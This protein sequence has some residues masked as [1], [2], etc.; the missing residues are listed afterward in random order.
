M[1]ETL[2]SEMA[3]SIDP[4]AFP[5]S[6]SAR[7]QLALVEKRFGKQF[8]D[9]RGVAEK[10]GGKYRARFSGMSE[11]E[12]RN[13]CKTLKAKKQPCMVMPLRPPAGA[14]PRGGRSAC[15]RS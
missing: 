2:P 7:E 8:D 9:A 5:F 6:G 3:W 14:R 1:A 10:D 12:A 13:A 15:S 4:D 11:G